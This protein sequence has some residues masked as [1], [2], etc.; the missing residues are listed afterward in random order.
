MMDDQRADAFGFLG[1]P[2]IQTPH[3]DAL[4]ARG[5][6]FTRACNAG[7][8]EG[9]VC[10]PSRAMLHTGRG[11]WHYGKS[12][13]TLPEDQ[14]TLGQQLQAAGYRC[15]GIGKWHNN[16]AAYTR[17]FDSGAEIFFGGMGDPW[18][19]ELCHF[20]ADGDYPRTPRVP[21]PFN[22]KRTTYRLCDHIYPGRHASEVFADA[23]VDFLESYDSEAPFFL[24]VAFTAPHDPR[25]APAAWHDRYPREAITLPPNY[26]PGHPF[27]N[28]EIIVR[29]EKLAPWPRTQATIREH[30]ADYYAMMSHADEQIGRIHEALA[31]RSDASDTIVVHTGDHGLAV[32]SHGLMGKQNL[33]EHSIR[34]PMILAGPDIKPDSRDDRLCFGMDLHRTLLD[35]AGAENPAALDS[36]SLFGPERNA[37]CFNYKDFQQA[38]TDGHWKV[39][40]YPAGEDRPEQIQFFDLEAD[41]HEINDLAQDGSLRDERE[42]ALQALNTGMADRP[43]IASQPWTPRGG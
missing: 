24:Y 13:H 15:H 14:P 32:G 18:N 36:R 19:L 2:D 31:N 40:H 39:I 23:A 26:A 43:L 34:I 4:A 12:A 3:L 25:L 8:N 28:G 20:Q 22:G 29:D 41:P 17:S 10:T 1:H 21:D 6:C 16:P 42:R 7:A 33:Y 37:L 38:W 27:D 5:R 11:F 9:A 35:A 30:L